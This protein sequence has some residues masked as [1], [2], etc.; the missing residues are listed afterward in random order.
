[1]DFV[2]VRPSLGSTLAFVAV[3]VGVALAF[4]A[5]VWGGALRALGPLPARRSA[6]RACGVTLL[7]LAVSAGLAASGALALPPRG[8][9]VVAYVLASFGGALAF[10]FSALGLRIAQALPLYALVGF[11][12]FRLPL[13]FV[14]HEWYMQGVLPVQMTYAGRNYDIVTGFLALGL[15]PL[16][17][18]GKLSRRSAWAF[19]LIGSALLLNVVQIAIRSSPVPLRT[20]MNE[21]PVLLALHAPYTWIFPV[22]VGGAL[23]GHALTF[24]RLLGAEQPLLDARET[25]H[26]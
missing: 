15:A 7:V 9:G 20:Y 22:C 24:R 23:V 21:P 17:A 26:S 18:L 14:L 25:S 3:V 5:A 11:Q 2:M 10:S 4:P 19:N 8:L 12:V 6:L 13:E 16:L 1:M